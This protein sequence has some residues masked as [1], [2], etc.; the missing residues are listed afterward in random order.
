MNIQTVKQRTALTP[1]R[2]PYWA[3]LATGRHIGY[4]RKDD[5]GSWIAR[6]YDPATRK[7]IY[8]ALPEVSRVAA[9][10]Q[11]SEAS[12]KAREW[13]NHLDRG[14]RP[15]TITV[16]EACE[17]YAKDQRDKKGDTAAD[18]AEK[19][20]KRYINDDPIANIQVDKLQRRHVAEWRKRMSA[21]PAAPPRRGAKYKDA[22][23]PPM[24]KRTDSTVNR[25]MV[26]VRAALN[27]AK[28]EGYVTTDF[29][30]SEPL[31]PK[32]NADGRR[33]LYIDRA[34]RLAL[35]NAL[36]SDLAAFVRGLCLLPLRPGA[37]A[38]IKVSDFDARAGILH[39]KLD[40]AGSNRKIP[41]PDQTAKM[42][43]EQM[44]NKLP[45]ALLFTRGDGEPWTKDYWKKK[46]SSAAR[47]AELP[48][49]VTLYTIRHSVIT[50][51]VT[52]GFDVFT[53]ARLAGTSVLMIQNHYC[54]VKE[55][56]ARDA[57]AGLSL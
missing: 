32:A 7:R 31:K 9:S 19:R 41:L 13:F 35:I 36:P 5:G 44:K 6:A 28:R 54:K 2:E 45:G 37:L 43:R 21:V 40:K 4:R 8:R 14:G 11:F 25:D 49:G 57:L 1:R 26:C 56:L 16:A 22:P 10:E 27:Y 51:L 18:D 12:R 34:Q 23:A 30:W 15:E 50:D 24:R 48:E 52:G 53:I 17:L 39:V 42:L 29:A 46:V 55:E 20:F 33:D 38:K 47:D 3:T